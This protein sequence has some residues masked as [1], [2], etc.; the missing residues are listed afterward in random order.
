MLKPYDANLSTPPESAAVAAADEDQDVFVEE[1]LCFCRSRT[2]SGSI[3]IQ[4]CA[5]VP[6]TDDPRGQRPRLLD[7]ITCSE[8]DVPKSFVPQNEL[9]P[10]KPYGRLRPLSSRRREDDARPSGLLP[11]KDAQSG[12]QGYDADCF[13]GCLGKKDSDVRTPPSRDPRSIASTTR[14]ST[15]KKP[16]LTR[17]DCCANAIGRGSRGSSSLRTSGG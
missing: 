14:Y 9:H 8:K 17:Y 3:R 11:L 13:R 1:L 15:A 6:R 16:D 4:R 2:A 10:L 7:Q 5:L 12:D